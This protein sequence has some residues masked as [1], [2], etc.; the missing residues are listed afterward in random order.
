MR[1]LERTWRAMDDAGRHE[2]NL[3]MLERALDAHPRDAELHLLLAQT[4]RSHLGS[5]C[6]RRS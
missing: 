1:E 5:S 2:E 6:S 3:R 4:R